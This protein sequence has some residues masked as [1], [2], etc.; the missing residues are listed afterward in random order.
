MEMALRHANHLLLYKVQ[1][2]CI[3]MLAAED[4]VRGTAVF[5]NF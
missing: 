3:D 2:T 1:R 5:E 4:K